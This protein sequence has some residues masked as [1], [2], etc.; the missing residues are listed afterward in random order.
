M[1][2]A[3]SGGDEEKPGGGR[4]DAAFGGSRRASA[5]HALRRQAQIVTETDLPLDRAL[6]EVVGGQRG[7][8]RID[9]RRKEPKAFSHPSAFHHLLW[10]PTGAA[11]PHFTGFEKTDDRWHVEA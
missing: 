3:V 11:R 7:P 5:F 4:D 9:D 8:R 10:R 1:N 6:V 2:L